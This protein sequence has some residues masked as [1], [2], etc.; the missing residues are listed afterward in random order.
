MTSRT[1][2][3]RRCGAPRCEA[4]GNAY[5]PYSQFPVGA[6]ALVDDGRVVAGCNV[7]NASYG[8]DPVRRVRPGVGAARQP[9]AA[10]W[11]PSPASTATATCSCRVGGAGSCCGSTAAR[12]CSSTPPE[13]PKPMIEVLPLAFGR[14]DLGGE[15]APSRAAEPFD[16]VDVIRAKR[17]GAALSDAQIDWVIVGVHPRSRRRRAD[18]GAGDGGPA[19]RADRR[20]ARPLDGRDDRLGASGS[21]C[22]R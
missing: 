2:T 13:G 12:T 8:L 17:D 7:E 19:A 1:S 9:A 10:G 5:A 11:W 15:L 4:M 6:A 22:R 18:V 16:A 20:R 21:T 14:E 3:G